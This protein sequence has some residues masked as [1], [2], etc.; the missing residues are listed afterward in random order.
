MSLYQEKS[1]I[2][3][4]ITS[5]LLVIFCGAAVGRADESRPPRVRAAK[6]NATAYDQNITIDE[7]SQVEIELEATG[8]EGVELTY[9]I[10]LRPSY[11]KLSE[12]KGNLVTYRPYRDYYG[13]DKFKFSAYS[14]SPRFTSNYATVSITVKAVPDK[15]YAE[16]VEA[17]TIQDEPIEI[18]LVG[19]DADGDDLKYRVKSQ[20]A[21]GKLE[22]VD[23]PHNVYLYTPKTDFAGKDSFTFDA[24]DGNSISNPATVDINVIGKSDD[25]FMLFTPVQKS[26]YAARVLEPLKVETPVD[27]V[28]D[29]NDNLYILSAPAGGKS[30]VLVCNLDLGVQRRFP[31][32]ASNPRGIAVTKDKLFYVTDTG[33][34]RVLR[35]LADGKPDVSFGDNGSVGKGGSGDGEFD[36]PWA[37]GMDWN[38]NIYISDSGNNRVQVF[39]ASGKFKSQW[40]QKTIYDIKSGRD[41]FAIRD[42]D[43]ERAHSAIL[44]RP[45]HITSFDQIHAEDRIPIKRPTGFFLNG[46][47]MF[48]ADTENHKIKRLNAGSGY[49]QSACGRKGSAQGCFNLPSDTAY[50]LEMDQLI[51][52]D[53]GNNR[54]E[55]L[56]LQSYGEF[57]RT[58]SMPC[59]QEIS[60]QS[61]SGPLGVA[62]VTK[63]PNQFIYVADTGNNR[64]V[65]LQN[66]LFK[67]GTSPIDVWE[68][69]K[70]ALLADD[71][72]KALTFISSWKRDD[73]AKILEAMR[74]HFKDF[75]GRMG[76]LVPSSQEA[77]TAQ[78]ELLTTDPNGDTFAF[79]VHFGMDEGGNWKIVDF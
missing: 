44:S 62:V 47:V 46:D 28:I 51:V 67:P 57:F 21:N 33:G 73:Y 29:H 5:V 9:G 79:P 34:N 74:P 18:D 38:G 36:K 32:D 12:V 13:T 71:T 60:D 23:A 16:D 64:V 49:L 4:I 53:S 6:A 55:V 3:C 20:P 43:D 22:L 58:G 77:G 42:E 8:P 2:M 48:L 11:G 19:F 50:D 31:L 37:V 75:V 10:N 54:I 35:Y 24:D 76:D 65:K 7:D 59:V 41:N 72:D 14:K 1:K 30:E 40:Q 26:V 45:R 70:A 68:Q 69:F 66:G 56:Q 25:L 17:I 52:A 15:P 63:Q 61:L 39:D 78:Y 27:L